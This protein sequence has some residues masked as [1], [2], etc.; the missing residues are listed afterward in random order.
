MFMFCV[1]D[2]GVN[3]LE[4]AES[5]F[6]RIHS[7]TLI[8]KLPVMSGGKAGTLFSGILV[9]P[10]LFKGHLAFKNAYSTR[11]FLIAISWERRD[12]HGTVFNRS[13]GRII[14]S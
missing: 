3:V 14:K 6:G 1:A 13:G 5:V 10:S 8:F 11:A 9:E 12:P 7:D 2:Q 4:K